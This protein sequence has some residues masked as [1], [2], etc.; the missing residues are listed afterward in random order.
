[1]SPVEVYP[2]A[3]IPFQ[4]GFDLERYFHDLFAERRVKGEWFALEEM[5]FEI[6]LT[7]FFPNKSLEGEP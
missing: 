2:W 1:M 4:F 5:D 3:Y 6:V 7:L